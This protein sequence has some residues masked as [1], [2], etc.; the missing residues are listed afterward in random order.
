[1]PTTPLRVFPSAD[2]MGEYL[3]ERLLRRIEEA[4]L[5]GARFLLGCPTGRTPRP[6]LGALARRL[7]E[8]QQDLSHLVF[9]MMDEYLV[10]GES[11]LESASTDVPW[12]CHHYA[13]DEIANRLNAGL[14]PA[15]RLRAEA[16]WFPDPRDP[17]DYD[18]RI[19]DA[20]GI[21]L[22]VLASGASDGHVAFNGPG[23]A[24]DSRTRV[25]EL[26]T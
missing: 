20:G 11:G 24:R 21:D 6:L 4:R 25:I 16:I 10:S 18:V 9:V 23:A 12:S 5:S 14:P 1:M 26:A 17:A 15:R 19:A 7:A 13:R 8:T 22:F 3:A 2:A